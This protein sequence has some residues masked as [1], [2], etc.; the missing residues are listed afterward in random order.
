MS[1]PIQPSEPDSAEEHQMARTL[2]ARRFAIGALLVAV[3][4]MLS[5]ATYGVVVIRSVQQDNT[6][7]LNSAERAAVAAEEAAKDAKHTAKLVEGCVNPKGKCAQRGQKQTA[8]AIGDIGQLQVNAVACAFTETAGAEVIPPEE[9]ARR[10]A[11]C[12]GELSGG[13]AS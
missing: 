11:A 6:P 3:V 12:L 9:L 13:P 4:A 8:K 10:I 1:A 2:V 5:V 7:T